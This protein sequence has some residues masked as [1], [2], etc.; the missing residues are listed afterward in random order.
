MRVRVANK[1]DILGY[2]FVQ[3]TFY[4]NKIIS[5]RGIC[6]LFRNDKKIRFVY[7]IHESIRESIKEI[8]R[9]GRSGI[10]I[11][12]YP[13]LNEEKKKLYSRLLNIKKKKFPESNVD[14]EIENEEKLFNIS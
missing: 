14:K 8:G 10:V 1:K 7:P 9:I 4:K 5:I 2:R 11:K 12:H 3:K 6:R 13:K